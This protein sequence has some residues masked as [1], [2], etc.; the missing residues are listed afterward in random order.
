ME[1]NSATE[2]CVQVVLC[3]LTKRLKSPF[4]KRFF[5]LHTLHAIAGPTRQPR[6]ASLLFENNRN[7]NY[8]ILAHS[9]Q[10]QQQQSSWFF[11]HFFF[12]RR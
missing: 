2:L 11:L 8:W 5:Y 3:R 9:G 7:K 4:L 10:Q 12:L 6:T 1:R